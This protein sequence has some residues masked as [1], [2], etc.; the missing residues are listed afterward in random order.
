[1][2]LADPQSV[3]IAGTAISLPRTAAGDGTSTYTSADGNVRLIVSN[4]KTA[5]SG[6]F[7][8]TVRIEHRKVAA[9]PFTSTLN[10]QYG[11]TAYAVFDVPA[12]GYTVAQ[13]KEVW[14][15]FAA[16]L[17]ASTGALVT[18]VLGGEN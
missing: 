2:A 9:D 18:K 7:R 12:V 11:M 8:R 14:D 6:R 3:T 1:M 16:L 13:Q 4:A 15:G 10:A 17:A 5:K